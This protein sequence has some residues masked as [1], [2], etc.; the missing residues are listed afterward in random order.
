[1]LEG[2]GIT[3]C[4]PIVSI[5]PE[6]SPIPGTIGRVLPSY[7]TR[8]VDPEADLRG[9]G[10]SPAIGSPSNSA[11]RQASPLPQGATQ[12]GETLTP[13]QGLLLVRGPCVFEG[14]L[15]YTGPQPFVELDGKR[16]YVTGDILTQNE[17]G[18]LTFVARR[19]RFVKMGGEMISLPAIE[20]ALEPHWPPLPGESGKPAQPQVAIAATEADRPEIVLFTSLALSRE[21]V[22]D[23]LQAAGLSSLHFVRR[24]VQVEAIPLLGTGKTDYRSLQ[25]RLKEHPRF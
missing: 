20:A 15:N 24:I 13:R 23:K 2:Y 11:K 22:N 9:T 14:Y 5:T 1:V 3:E 18:V 17:H 8:L 12:A 25:G 10:V 4:S 7:E 21:D 19:K 16:W 6:E